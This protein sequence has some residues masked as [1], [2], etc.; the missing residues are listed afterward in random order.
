MLNE[1]K[2]SLRKKLLLKDLPSVAGMIKQRGVMMV[3]EVFIDEW[4]IGSLISWVMNSLLLWATGRIFFRKRPQQKAKTWRIV[5]AGFLGGVYFFYFCYRWEIGLL[6]QE[7]LFFFISTG[8]VMNTVAFTQL[9][10]RRWIILLIKT[11]GLFFVLAI[12][13]VGIT[14]LVYY[15]YHFYFHRVLRG[16]EIVLVNVFSLLVLTELGWGLV[17]ETIWE[18]SCLVQL[19]I[20]IADR[21]KEIPALLDTGNLL[22]D[23]ITKNPVVMVE[24]NSITELLPEK[25]RRLS[26][27]ILQGDLP[28]EEELDLSP[29]WLVRV[30]LL[31]FM[32]VGRDKGFL[33]GIRPDEVIIGGKSFVKQAQVIIGLYHL[34]SAEDRNYQALLPGALLAVE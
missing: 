6:G 4:L 29:D 28:N 7:E 27:T 14:S 17:H 21:T 10:K 1:A 11:T 19:K 3:R 25:I 9:H 32:S 31:S 12:M 8:I 24:A 15:L 23:P 34:G 20:T 5:F 18:K 22:V 13:T 2:F 33:L 16:W 30:R 26:E